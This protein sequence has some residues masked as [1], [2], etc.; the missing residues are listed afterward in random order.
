[1]RQQIN[2]F[3]SVLIDKREPLQG[4]QVRLILLLFII[5]LGGLSLLGYWQMQRAER[6][7]AKLQQQKAALATV[8]SRLEQQYPERRKSALLEEEI[9][10]SET[11]LAGQQQLL[12]YFKKRSGQDNKSFLAILDGLA[13]HRTEGVWL[14]RIRLGSAGELAL[15]G[16][17]LRPE[18][19]P[20]Y[21]QLL[22]S[23]Q[24]FAGK[25]FSRLSVTRLD[26]TAGQVDFSLESLTEDTP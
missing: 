20:E 13:R 9:H 6:Q 18:Q 7:A 2:L 8:V 23:Q 3:Q 14:N 4:R 19:V 1:M 16:R 17:A 15:T 5:V 10:R 11:T 22:G 26:K 24:I 21:V 12:G 25:L